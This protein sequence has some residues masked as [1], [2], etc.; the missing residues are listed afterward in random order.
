MFFWKAVNRGL[1]I[2]ALWDSRELSWIN[3]CAR[4]LQCSTK[5]FFFFPKMQ[6]VWELRCLKPAAKHRRVSFALL[7]LYCTSAGTKKHHSI[8]AL[9]MILP[10]EY[11]SSHAFVYFVC[12]AG[13]DRWQNGSDVI[14]DY[15]TSD[16]LIRWDSYQN[17]CDG[18]GTVTSPHDAQK[19]S[20]GRPPRESEHPS[21][22]RQPTS[23]PCAVRM[24]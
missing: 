5:I 23:Y 6:L 18:E 13:A 2:L 21:G 4:L 15:N 1:C 12:A 10:P 24:L 7:S 17:I 8:F 9:Y 20:A 3:S 14:V 19:T 11:A 22:K 16:P